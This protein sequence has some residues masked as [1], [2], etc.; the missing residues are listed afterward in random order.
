MPRFERASKHER[1]Y[2]SFLACL[3]E[4]LH[5]SAR[6]PCVE[7]KCHGSC[8]RGCAERDEDPSKKK[9]FRIADQPD[10]GVD[11]DAI[12][13]DEQQAGGP[14]PL[15]E[16]AGDQEEQPGEQPTGLAE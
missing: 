4:Q 16:E 2:A 12:H 13:Q 5:G 6:E 8:D 14:W 3:Q 15:A 7:H 9:W 10:E 1:I 11:G